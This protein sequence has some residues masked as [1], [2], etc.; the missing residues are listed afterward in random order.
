MN[1]LNADYNSDSPELDVA[2]GDLN[3]NLNG[4]SNGDASSP[5]T[6][7]DHTLDMKIHMDIQEPESDVRHEPIPIRVDVKLDHASVAPEVGTPLDPCEQHR[8]FVRRRRY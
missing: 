6:P 1:A 4:L 3:A 7:V 5:T 2:P 8:C